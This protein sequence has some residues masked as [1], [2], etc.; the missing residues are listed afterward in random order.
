VIHRQL[1]NSLVIKVNHLY[2]F[3][4]CESLNDEDGA[5]LREL[6]SVMAALKDIGIPE[7]AVNTTWS[8]DFRDI[9]KNVQGYAFDSC[10]VLRPRSRPHR[11]VFRFELS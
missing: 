11:F 10:E 9:L 4:Q 3:P 6:Q 2:P 5:F 7:A 1:D 8:F